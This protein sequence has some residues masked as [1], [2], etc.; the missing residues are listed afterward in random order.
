LTY[1]QNGRNVLVKI[2]LSVNVVHK[3][4]RRFTAYLGRYAIVQAG[5]TPLEV[6]QDG[7]MR[8]DAT[9]VTPLEITGQVRGLHV[10]CKSHEV[11]AAAV[12][13]EEF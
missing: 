7:L 10:N 8:N 2:V 4:L 1:L 13:I 6:L 5:V 11:Q 12:T 3:R 9:S